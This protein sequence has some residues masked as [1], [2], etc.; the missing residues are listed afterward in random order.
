MGKVFVVFILHLFNFW[1]ENVTGIIDIFG[2]MART[3]IIR[4]N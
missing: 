2:Q 1:Y 4:F 3:S